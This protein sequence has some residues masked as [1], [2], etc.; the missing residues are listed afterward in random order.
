MAKLYNKYMG[1]Y[2]SKVN[3]REQK[4]FY[5]YEKGVDNTDTERKAFKE[6]EELY[7]IPRTELWISALVKR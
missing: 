4:W 2:V 3:D 6:I 5:R 1:F 7:G